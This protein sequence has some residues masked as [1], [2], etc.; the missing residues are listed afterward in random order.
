M[1][2]DVGRDAERA[3]SFFTG[4]PPER[5]VFRTRASEGVLWRLFVVELCFCRRF[6]GLVIR[7]SNPNL[8][9]ANKSAVTRE[10]YRVHGGSDIF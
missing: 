8:E 5:L 2:F 6:F 7:I 10:A 3:T 1:G 4:S 9:F